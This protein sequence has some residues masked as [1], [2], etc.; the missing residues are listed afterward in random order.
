MGTFV[1]SIIVFN[2]FSTML[3]SVLLGI[4]LVAVSLLLEN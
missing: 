2:N 3:I 1:Q 4:T